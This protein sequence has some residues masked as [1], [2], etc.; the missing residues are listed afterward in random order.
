MVPA[1]FQCTFSNVAQK[2]AARKRKLTT[3][4]SRAAMRGVTSR[5]V[6]AIASAESPEQHAAERTHRLGHVQL[7][8]GLRGELHAKH[9][10]A[11]KAFVEAG[12]V[13]LAR[14]ADRVDETHVAKSARRIERL[15]GDDERLL[16]A[17]GVVERHDATL[18]HSRRPGLEIAAD[19][20][21]I[22]RT[23]D[24]QQLDRLREL[25]GGVL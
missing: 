2:T 20:R 17:A 9:E 14:V 12:P 3:G 4:L 10:P 21:C 15:S 7:A 19:R 25:G 18:D 24:E 13:R 8:Q 22:V 16:V 6:T 11:A 1:V 23:V 5:L